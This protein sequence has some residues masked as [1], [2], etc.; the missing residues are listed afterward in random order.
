MIE[1]GGGLTVTYDEGDDSCGRG[2][3]GICD[4]DGYCCAFCGEK[5]VGGGNWL[6]H[7]VDESGLWP[8][9]WQ[10]C[11]FEHVAPLS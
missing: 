7:C 4:A 11:F 8:G 9:H 6:A 3:F 10:R 5:S 2:G 1:P